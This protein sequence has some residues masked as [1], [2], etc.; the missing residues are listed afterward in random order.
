MTVHILVVGANGQLGRCLQAVYENQ[1]NCRVTALDMPAIDITN[2]DTIEQVISLAPDAVV[3]AAAW[4]NVDTAEEHQA[5]VYAVNAL[6][7]HHLATACDACGAAYVQVSTN[8]VFDGQPGRFYYEYD[9]PNPGGVYARSKLAGERAA[10]QACRR[11]MI[12]RLAWLYAPGGNNF[13]A[14]ITAAADKHGQLR[15]VDD[16][17]GNPTYAPDAAQ[18]IAA[19]IDR[20]VPGIYHVVNEGRASRYDL[21]GRVLRLSGRGDVPLTPI[22]VAEWPR[23]SKPPLHAVVVNQAAAALGI[24][25]RPWQEALVD[26]VEAER[27]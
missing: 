22:S 23:A 15:V 27:K 3:N 21:A 26:Y 14:K 13:P 1:S 4:T 16:E 8:E 24:R 18:A 11:T 2:A 7:T 17:I 6:G 9:T 20:D 25:L 5:L 12:V 19:L 10:L